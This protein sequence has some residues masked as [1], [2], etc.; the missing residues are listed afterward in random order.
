MKKKIIVRH[1]SYL[2]R[3]YRDTGQQNIKLDHTL[4][5]VCEHWII[6]I[7]NLTTVT[8][9]HSVCNFA[10]YL[11][12]WCLLHVAICASLPSPYASLKM[13][14]ILLSFGTVYIIRNFPYI[15]CICSF[16]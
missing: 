4:S 10:L 15:E 12:N 2:Q 6:L 13:A 3:L 1:V 7:G 5:T 8:L 16:D 9:T 11:R 14:E